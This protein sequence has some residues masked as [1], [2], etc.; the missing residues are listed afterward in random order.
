MARKKNITSEKIIELYMDEVL[1]GETSSTVYAFSKKH[2]FDESDFYTYF[3][4]FETLDKNIF[5][6]FCS[7]T[8]EMLLQNDDY[9]NYD[10][11]SKLLSFYYTF[12]EL[13]TAN[14]SFVYIKLKTNKN[15]LESLKLLSKLRGEFT[16]FIHREI[17]TDNIDFKNKTINKIQEHGIVESSWLHL[18]FTL[19]FWLEDESV[20]F[21]KTDVFIEKSVKASFDLK[22]TTPIQSVFDF[23]KFLWK[24]KMPAI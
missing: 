23:A 1:T 16:E 17:H 8:I 20:N 13:L 15:K 24:E 5:A 6:I 12:F 10:S 9:K 21:E 11:K 19:Q 7:K 18:L 14:R 4:S 22:D 3:S 2:N